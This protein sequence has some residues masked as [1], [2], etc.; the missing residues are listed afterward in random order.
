MTK[1]EEDRANEVMTG[2]FERPMTEEDEDAALE[3][4]DAA[5]PVSTGDGPMPDYLDKMTAKDFVKAFSDA[6]PHNV[7]MPNLRKMPRMARVIRVHHKC[8]GTEVEDGVTVPCGATLIVGVTKDGKLYCM[9]HAR[10]EDICRL[11]ARVSTGS[12]ADDPPED[13]PESDHLLVLQQLA[14]AEKDHDEA[15]KQ[16]KALRE[17]RDRLQAQN[18]SLNK[19]VYTLRA[20]LERRKKAQVIAFKALQL[21]LSDEEDDDDVPF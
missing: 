20:N 13:G 17:Q 14:E 9:D 2:H 4:V 21:G 8:Q 15:M 3:K 18:V 10:E 1:D 11:T 6:V 7:P 5:S 12:Y 16:V 19:E